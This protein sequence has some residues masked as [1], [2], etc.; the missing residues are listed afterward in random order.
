MTQS[1]NI[2]E[3]AT[4]L[5][6][7]QSELKN[8]KRTQE[9]PFLKS[10]YTDLATA[11]E[12]ARPV[13][14]K[15]G[16]SVI[17]LLEAGES[18]GQVYVRTML[19]HSSGQY[20]S[21]KYELKPTKDDPQGYGSAI[22]YARRYAYMAIVGLASEDDDG[23]AASKPKAQVMEDTQEEQVATTLKAGPNY[24]RKYRYTVENGKR[25]FKGWASS[26]ETENTNA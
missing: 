13:L 21:G 24:G 1:E 26:E 4:A 8:P 11:I 2:N 9:N 23:H 18:V 6:K 16:L 12:A 22:T 25:V 15:N 14:S 3:L 17:Q 20:I 5:A 10:S 19:L 7:A